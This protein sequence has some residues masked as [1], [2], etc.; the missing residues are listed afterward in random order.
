MLSRKHEQGLSL[1]FGG[2][3]AGV[4][5]AGRGPI[6]GPVVAAAVILPIEDAISGLND[7]KKLSAA[8]RAALAPEI[9]RI[10][11]VGIGL[12]TVEEIDEIN[13]L[14]ATMLAMTRAIES[15]RQHPAAVLIDGNRVPSP[16]S[17]PAEA[18]VKGD[19]KEQ[20]IAAASIIAKTHRDQI[21]CD[22]AERYPA[23][24]FERHA[25]YP[26]AAHLEALRT[27]GASPVHRQTFRPIREL[28]R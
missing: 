2:P 6:A 26:T 7:S 1:R 23:Y 19:A 17:C 25:G 15:L 22:L 9:L 14:W 11:D 16:L 13:I 21:M 5:E 12:A 10:C 4:D 3:V 24:G 8:R 28:G 27:H 20:S 18:L